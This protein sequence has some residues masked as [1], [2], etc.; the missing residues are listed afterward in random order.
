MI[1]VNLQTTLDRSEVS[2]GSTLQLNGQNQAR[3]VNIILK[4]GATGIGLSIV[5]A[6]VSWKVA[7]QNPMELD[8]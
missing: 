3:I 1:N 6:I 4:R 5:A 2:S 8:F 7:V